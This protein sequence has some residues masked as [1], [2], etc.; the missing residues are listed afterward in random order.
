MILK[1]L[2]FRLVFVFQI[3]EQKPNILYVISD[4]LWY[5]P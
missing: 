2:R 3:N 5:V 1:A 4:F